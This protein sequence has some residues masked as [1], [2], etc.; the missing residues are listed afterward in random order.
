M[1]VGFD[2]GQY[3]IP[4]VSQAGALMSPESAIEEF[5]RT[6]QHL[7]IFDTPEA[8]T[9]YGKRLSAAQAERPPLTPEEARQRGVL[10][11]LRKHG[12]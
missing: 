8:S 2:D 11:L 7:G 5:L 1:G 6:G 4:R 12:P 3:L 9:A 10:E